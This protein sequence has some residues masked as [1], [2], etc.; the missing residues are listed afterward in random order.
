M[1]YSR[2]FARFNRPFLDINVACVID[3]DCKYEKTE[4]NKKVFSRPDDSAIEKSKESRNK[5]FDDGDNIKTFVSPNWTLEFDVAISRGLREYFYQAVKL[6]NKTK[7]LEQ[8]EIIKIKSEADKELKKWI[9]EEKQD[10]E[11]AY[12]IYKKCRKNKATTAL[13]FA[14]ILEG[15]EK[16]IKSIIEKGDEQIRYLVEAIEHVTKQPET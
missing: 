9:R 10:D 7:R 14:K 15:E 3:S 16:K 12:E 8:E 13:W 1:H 11:I 5:K 6:A 2:I 4:N